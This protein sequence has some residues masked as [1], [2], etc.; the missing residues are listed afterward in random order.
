MPK[1]LIKHTHL[2]GMVRFKVFECN[3]DK[4]GLES[5]FELGSFQTEQ[6]AR[7]FIHHI[8]QPNLLVEV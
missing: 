3:A 2:A 1:Y 5:E 6:E 8:N 7:I 4:F